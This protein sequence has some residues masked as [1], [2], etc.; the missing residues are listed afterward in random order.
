MGPPDFLAP[1]VPDE[2]LLA[3]DN[4]HIMYPEHNQWVSPQDNGADLL[5]RCFCDPKVGLCCIT[6][7][8]PV[9]Q[10]YEQ[11]LDTTLHYR[12]LETQTEF[13]ATTTQIET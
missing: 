8:G 7:L 12:C 13:I 11:E 1:Y 4:Y 9:M 2:V 5:G 10:H 6:R 3:P